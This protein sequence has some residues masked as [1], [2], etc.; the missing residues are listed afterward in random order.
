MTEG[1]STNVVIA[2]FTT[3]LARLHLLSLMNVCPE[4]IHYTDTD[5][6]FALHERGANPLADSLGMLT[7]ELAPQ[8]LGTYIEEF[9]SGGPKN[10]GMRLSNGA[11]SWKVRG[12]T[13]NYKTEQLMNYGIMKEFILQCPTDD[14]VVIPDFR[15]QRNKVSGELRN[16]ETHKTYRFGYDKAVAYSDCSTRPYCFKM[17]C[18]SHLCPL[19]SLC[20]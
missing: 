10:Y 12:I 19:Y 5:S 9:M 1:N 6:C 20:S 14:T 15:I 7:D 13:Q 4:A 2:A 17:T 3:C 8:G 16:I 11:T 18:E